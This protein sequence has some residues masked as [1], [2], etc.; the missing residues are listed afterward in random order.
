MVSSLHYMKTVLLSGKMEIQHNMHFYNM[1]S[2]VM[3]TLSPR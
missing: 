1:R 3:M 2:I